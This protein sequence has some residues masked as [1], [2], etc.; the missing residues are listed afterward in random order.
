MAAS[1]Y[2]GGCAA[3][4]QFIT[5]IAMFTNVGCPGHMQLRSLPVAYLKWPVKGLTVLMQRDVIKAKA[6]ESRAVISSREFERESRVYFFPKTRASEHFSAHIISE[7]RSTRANGPG[8][9]FSQLG[10]DF[11]AVFS[12]IAVFRWLSTTVAKVW[13]S[14]ACHRVQL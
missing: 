12:A 6:C 11:S 5:Y 14:Y 8:F 2:R 9:I 3:A 1:P 10:A 7:N 4:I 13:R